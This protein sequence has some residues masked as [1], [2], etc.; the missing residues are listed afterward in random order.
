[1]VAGVSLLVFE[2]IESC[3]VAFEQENMSSS[4]VKWYT[5]LSFRFKSK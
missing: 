2:L 1:M 4:V 3:I 5:P